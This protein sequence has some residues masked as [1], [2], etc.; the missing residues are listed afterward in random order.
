MEERGD[1]ERKRE[2]LERQIVEG[3]I[4]KENIERRSERVGSYFYHYFG[5]GPKNKYERY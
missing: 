1:L 5:E 3:E 2:A 4:L